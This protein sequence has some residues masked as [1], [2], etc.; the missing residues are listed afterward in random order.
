[1]CEKTKV[2]KDQMICLKQ[3]ASIMELCLLILVTLEMTGTTWN[4]WEISIQ[5]YY[6]FVY[7]INTYKYEF[8]LSSYYMPVSGGSDTDAWGKKIS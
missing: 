5:S 6:F 7:E 8:M 3:N 2:E 4:Y 1:M